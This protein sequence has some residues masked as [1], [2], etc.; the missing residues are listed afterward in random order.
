MHKCHRSKCHNTFHE[1]S[2]DYVMAESG[3]V[4]CGH[5]CYSKSGET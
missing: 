5:K 3:N 1:D 4:Y 2:G